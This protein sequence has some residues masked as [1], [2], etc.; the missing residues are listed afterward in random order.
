MIK[1]ETRRHWIRFW[2]RKRTLVEKTGYIQIK[3][4]VYL[5]E[6]TNLPVWGKLSEG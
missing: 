2:N 3:F 5:I 6:C 4:G 1:E